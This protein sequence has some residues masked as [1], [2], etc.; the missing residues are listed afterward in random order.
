MTQT[1]TPHPDR[2]DDAIDGADEQQTARLELLEALPVRLAASDLEKMRLL[3]AEGKTSRAVDPLIVQIEIRR[4]REREAIPRPFTAAQQQAADEEAALQRLGALDMNR[5]AK[6]THVPNVQL[7]QMMDGIVARD[8]VSRTALL[9][10]AGYKSSS[11]GNRQLGYMR[12]SGS[13][14]RAQTIRLADA[15]R[16]ARA[17]GVE[18]REVVGL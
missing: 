13:S 17:L 5:L 12:A 11:H 15:A 10:R 4:A 3:A 2:V 8:D 9:T 16:V 6:G 7:R 18:P 14:R 1:L